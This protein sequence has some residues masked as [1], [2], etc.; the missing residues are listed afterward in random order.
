MINNI[1]DMKKTFLLVA[2][3]FAALSVM[4]QDEP[5]NIL[6]IG[7]SYTDV[8]NLPQLVQRV[9]ESAGARLTYTS[10][11]PGG[12]T[13]AQHC[14]NQSMALIRQGGW[15]VVV[16]Q[17]Q[18]QEPSFPQH[19]VEQQT[20]PYAAELV[21]A[22]YEANP[23]G[24]AMFYMTWGRKDGDQ[25]NAQYFPVLGTYEGMD[26]MLYERYLYMARANDASVCPVGRV[27]RYL[28]NN[29]PDIELYQ[30]DGSHPSMAGSYA[31]A[32]SFY[33]MIF[34]RSPLDVTYT[35]DL[36]VAQADIIR[37]AVK[38]VVFDTLNFWLR[39][40]ADTTQQ[41]TTQ[42]DT[43][44]QDTTHVGI[45]HVSALQCTVSP[46]PAKDYVMVRM[47]G[48]EGLCQGILYDPRGCVVRRITFSA[49]EQKID[50]NHLSAGV[51]TLSVISGKDKIS[52]RI[53][54]K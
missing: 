15:D 31:A 51:Y 48:N 10:N 42:T 17:A 3:L 26:S 34:H 19:Q 30:G 12:C 7:N 8:N 29:Y 35:A 41:D 44:H 52:R 16:L 33:S 24:E 11:T 45:T 1:K 13:F 20:F 22:I 14:Q 2:L 28:R 53:V 36:D 6:F 4:A 54:V 5:K 38:T 37:N 32:C 25:Q 9:S 47:Q 18:S 23:D 43:T 40:E 50:L 39:Q 49:N 27:W 21:Q 46:N